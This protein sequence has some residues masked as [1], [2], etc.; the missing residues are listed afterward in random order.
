MKKLTLPLLGGLLLAGAAC[1][2]DWPQWL[3]PG[4]NNVSK[5]TGLLQSW[6]KSGPKLLWTFSQ[7]GMGYSA[8]SI[9]GDRLYALGATGGQNYLFAVDVRSGKRLWAAPLAPLSKG[10]EERGNGPRGSPTVDGDHVYAL[11]ADGTLVC[12]NT[13]D[14]KKVWSKNFPK[15]LSGAKQNLQWGYSESPLVDG[16]QV[17]CMPGGRLG[18]VAALDKKTGEVRWRSEGLRDEAGFSSLVAAEFGGGRQYVV[19]TPEH[20][21]GVAA[22]DGKL[23]WSFAWKSIVATIPTPVVFDNHV[24]VTS[25]Y[26]AGCALVKVSKDGDKFR[27]DEVYANRNMT[28]QHGGVALVD[29]HIYGYSDNKGWVC[30]D[31]KTGDLVWQ[32]KK[33]GKGSM[34]YADGRLYCYTE[35]GGTAALVEATTAGWKEDGRFKLP[36]QSKLPRPEPNPTNNVWTH[37]VVANGRLY[38]RDQDLIFCFDVKAR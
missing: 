30:Q 21:A 37:P 6:P 17:V 14:G 2:D 27:A 15:D 4:R 10:Q 38:L 19:L 13:A 18:T 1:A 16:D 29:G 7:A 31:V 9:V 28:N 34:T 8:P 12:A 5:E 23:L 32:S 22:R 11:T 24:Y 35:S 3:G 36:R 25:G 33:L 26:N 20:V